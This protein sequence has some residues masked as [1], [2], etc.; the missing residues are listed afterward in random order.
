ML[1]GQHGQK[2]TT[3][4]RGERFF[5]SK[6]ELNKG[7]RPIFTAKFGDYPVPHNSDKEL[8]AIAARLQTHRTDSFTCLLILEKSIYILRKAFRTTDLSNLSFLKPRSPNISF[9]FKP[10]T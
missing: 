5:I 6:R 10:Y 9:L 3:R 8:Y 7:W 1:H 2:S 4:Y